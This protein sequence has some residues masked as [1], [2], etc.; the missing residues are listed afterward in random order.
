MCSSWCARLSCASVA[1]IQ[2]RQCVGSGQGTKLCCSLGGLACLLWC[3]LCQLP[4][5]T[6]AVLCAA[7]SVGSSM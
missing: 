6:Q 1:V 2:Q 5:R 4:S 7:R 3:A